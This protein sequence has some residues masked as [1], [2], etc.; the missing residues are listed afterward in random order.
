MTLESQRSHIRK[1]FPSLFVDAAKRDTRNFVPEMPGL[2]SNWMSR[3]LA[4]MGEILE[5]G[6]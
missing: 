3:R 4:K 2:R 1:Y 6:A 5:T